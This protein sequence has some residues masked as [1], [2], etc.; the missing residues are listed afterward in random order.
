[1][2]TLEEVK[3]LQKR[4]YNSISNGSEMLLSEYEIDE[5]I[6]A[7]EVTID[8]DTQLEL[9]YTVGWAGSVNPDH[10]RNA[11]ERFLQGPNGVL[12][13]RALWF[14]CDFWERYPGDYSQYIQD[15]ISGVEWDEER[16]CRR[17]SLEIAQ[18][19]LRE[20][21]D[22]EMLKSIIDLFGRFRGDRDV[23]VYALEALSNITREPFDEVNVV[24]DAAKKRAEDMK[25]RLGK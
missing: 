22:Y 25:S 5:T 17:T 18:E 24:I 15:Y 12:A 3:R 6:Q 8:P 21:D 23:E 9:L 19:F 1:M 14:L 7:L 4:A 10:Y 20:Y 11:L 16:C 13:C 2:W